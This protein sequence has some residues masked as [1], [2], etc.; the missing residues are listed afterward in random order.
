MKLYELK[1]EIK[2]L[3]SLV[4]PSISGNFLQPSTTNFSFP[5]LSKTIF[6]RLL[7]QILSFKSEDVRCPLMSGTCGG[8]FCRFTAMTSSGHFR[9]CILISSQIYELFLWIISAISF[10]VYEQFHYCSLL[11]KIL[12]SDFP[13]SYLMPTLLFTSGST[14]LYFFQWLLIMA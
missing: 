13:A 5:F 9:T 8:D 10:F 1:S 3:V 6:F 14:A 12:I 2:S 4:S 11:T 7:I